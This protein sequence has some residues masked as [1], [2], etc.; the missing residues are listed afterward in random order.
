MARA[1]FRKLILSTLA[2]WAQI[3]QKGFQKLDFQH[4]SGLGLD[5]IRMDLRMI[6]LRTL[7]AW[8]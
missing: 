1:G 7:A 5:I 8:A 2:V 3:S 4:F 6:I